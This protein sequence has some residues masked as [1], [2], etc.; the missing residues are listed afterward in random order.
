MLSE[1]I[2]VFEE[3]GNGGLL[4][5]STGKE[6]LLKNSSKE[7]EVIS[8]EHGKVY[9][10]EMQKPQGSSGYKL[11]KG[12][13]DST[14]I[15][16]YFRPDNILRVLDPKNSPESAK[17]AELQIEQVLFEDDDR[18]IVVSAGQDGRNRNLC[19][20]KKSGGAETI[21]PFPDF[22]VAS[23][24]R[25]EF[26]PNRKRVAVTAAHEKNDFHESRE[27]MVVDLHKKKVVSKASKLKPL[28]MIFCS[29][30]PSLFLNWADNDLLYA[31]SAD[32]FAIDLN[33]GKPPTK[34][35]EREVV[36]A[37]KNEEHQSEGARESIGFFEVVHGQAFYKG[38]KKPV[39]DVLDAS[40]A[41]V[42]DLA[43]DCNGK[44][45][46]FASSDSALCLVD[47]E[48][49]KKR[50]LMQ[51]WTYDIQWLP[52]QMSRYRE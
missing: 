22:W 50:T 40:G 18:F 10:L 28:P 13:N 16:D 1:S 8:V 25:I 52:K 38:D 11:K 32:E 41:K 33:T 49:K 47:G 43:V 21:C 36:A 20:V 3:G 7:I 45:L 31:M 19:S 17:L 39:A 24:T 48:K 35:R 46:A 23:L 2:I 27:L 51:G 30:P 14:V 37:V 26:S 5:L 6:T 42:R 29:V 9:F 15:E 4:D 34:E 44:W 12:D